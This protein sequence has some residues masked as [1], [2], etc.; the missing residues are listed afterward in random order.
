[1]DQATA[2]NALQFMSRVQLQG[3]EVPAFMQ[4]QQALAGL[5]NPQDDS[6]TPP[7]NPDGQAPGQAPA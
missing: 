7:L 2:R 4:V 6:P 1:M 5:A 3:N